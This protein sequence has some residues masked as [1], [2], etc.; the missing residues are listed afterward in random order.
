MNT[1]TLFIQLRIQQLCINFELKENNNNNTIEVN[2]KQNNNDDDDDMEI[3]N[4]I[5]K[6]SAQRIS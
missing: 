4:M 6:Q 5:F 1:A 2:S 3:I